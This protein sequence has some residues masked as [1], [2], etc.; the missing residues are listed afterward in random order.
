MNEDK[1][2]PNF[3][4]AS[5]IIG[6]R[7]IL[8]NAEIE[9][10]EF[11][12]KLRLD[13]TKNKYLSETSPEL[14]NQI[15]W[16]KKYAEDDSQV[17]FIICTKDGTP[18]GTV[19]MYDKQKNSFCWGSWILTTGSSSSYSIES[20]LIIYSYGQILGFTKAHF[21]VRKGNTSVWRF[22]EKFGAKRIGETEDD[23]IYNISGEDINK[24]IK[25]YK[26]YLPNNISLPRNR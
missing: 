22:H 19:R 26:R 17:Y 12:L 2:E 3:K 21:D 24:S 15:N 10:A 9:D 11:I 18:I 20:A 23:Y 7:L 8:R 5:I 4:K 14:K 16:L 25:R 1:S 6:N 13:S